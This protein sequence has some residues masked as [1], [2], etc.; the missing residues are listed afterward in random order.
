MTFGEHERAV[1]RLAA[2]LAAR[3]VGPGDRVGLFAPNSPE[4]TATFFAV[5]EVGAIVVPC[6]GWWSADE[7]AHACE[8]T[9]PDGRGGRRSTRRG[10]CP[11][12]RRC[13]R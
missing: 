10:A 4:W 12:D 7:V 8:L 5:L 1:G 2:R 9:T 11:T 3:G 13:W 6:N